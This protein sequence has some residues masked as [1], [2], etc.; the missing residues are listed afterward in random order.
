MRPAGDWRS[1][2]DSIPLRRL[3]PRGPGSTDR[4]NDSGWRPCIQ[5]IPVSAIGC[6]E[7]LDR[8]KPAGRRQRPE[9]AKES[10]YGRADRF[11][12]NSGVTRIYDGSVSRI[13]PHPMTRVA[14]IADRCGH[15]TRSIP[16]IRTKTV[17]RSMHVTTGGG[18]VFQTATISLDTDGAIEAVE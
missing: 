18:A 15:G 9:R 14:S 5:T 8:L 1:R 16:D 2:T 4:T 12:L 17:I 13:A 11:S 7:P 6:R 3:A 10:T